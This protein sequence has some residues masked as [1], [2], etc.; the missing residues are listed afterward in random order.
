MSVG[1]CQC[2]A[3]WCCGIA[4]VVAAG[5]R[6][7]PAQQVHGCCAALCCGVSAA[8]DCMHTCTLWEYGAG[9]GAQAGS[10]VVGSRPLL[11][12]AYLIRSALCAPFCFCSY[13]LSP[14]KQAA[15]ASETRRVWCS[16]AER[17][18][19]FALKVRA[20]G[21]WVRGCCLLAGVLVGGVQL[22]GGRGGVAGP[23]RDASP[24]RVPWDVCA[25][26]AL[27]CMVGLGKRRG[28]PGRPAGP[29][30]PPSLLQLLCQHTHKRP[31]AFSPC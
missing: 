27:G 13:A 25:Q 2:A 28:L 14:E 15:V 19:M 5:P 21:V 4:A 10:R 20:G 29:P 16:L 24:G 18:G 23:P 22:C 17:L 11:S 7:P 31:A 1:C 12:A 8:C 6:R 26:G 9:C 3:L 30:W